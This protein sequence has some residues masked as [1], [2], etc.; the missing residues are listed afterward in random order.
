MDFPPGYGEFVQRSC[1]P[2]KGKEDVSF[3][4]GAGWVLA[5]GAEEYPFENGS[6]RERGIVRDARSEPGAAG[7][8]GS[9]EQSIGEQLS[10]FFS[11]CKMP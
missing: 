9:G 10:G 7:K 2:E 8:P 6:P 4:G 1:H 5:D 11:T 3:Q